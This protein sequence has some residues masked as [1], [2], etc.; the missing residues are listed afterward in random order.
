MLSTEQN[1]RT[2]LK[3]A[4]EGHS[5]RGFAKK[6]GISTSFLSEV[7]SAKKSISVEL[8]FKIA[9][10]LN[11]TDTETR[12]FCLLVQ[13]EQEKDPA[14]RDEWIQKLNDL[15]P[16][17]KAYDLSADLFRCIGEWHHAAIL[18][19]TYLAGFRLAPDTAAK[20]LGISRVEAEL[21][22]ERLLRLEL[23]E[24]HQGRYRKAHDT[25]YSEAQIPNSAFKGFHHQILTKAS[26]GLFTLN[27]KE[28][29]SATDVVAFDSK[30]LGEVD[31]L[32]R[33]FSAAVLKLAGRAKCKDGVYALAVHFLPI[34]TQERRKL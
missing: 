14:Y 34:T 21:A 9:T 32:S 26:Q 28:R 2:V 25:V 33:E 27:P 10:R 12:H 16:K 15:T 18:E 31:R 4:H 7:L 13:L 17:R 24:K 22:M 29:I 6:L 1:Y 8:A 23:L 20:R 3:T 19:L 5:L 11:L 30:H